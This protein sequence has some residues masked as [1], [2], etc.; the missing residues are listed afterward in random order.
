MRIFS[1]LAFC[2]MSGCVVA[3]PGDPLSPDGFGENAE[4]T[5]AENDASFGAM[6]NTYRVSTGVGVVEFDARLS[7][8]AQTHAQ[9]M[10]DRNY[11]DHENPEGMDVRARMIAEGYTP[12]A[13]G[14]NIAGRQSSETEVLNAWINSKDH[15]D[16]LTAES[17][18]DYGLGLAVG[19]ESRWVLVMGREAR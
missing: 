19:S 9:D 3:L 6:M 1:I 18:E 2:A 10:V 17:F 12:D 16:I 11:F 14:E 5:T 8:A 7:A 13:W 4:Q 15:N